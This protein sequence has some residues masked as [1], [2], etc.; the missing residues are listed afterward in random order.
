M[1]HLVKYKPE[2]SANY[3][4]KNPR[5]LM[6]KTV[7]HRAL[8]K[9]YEFDL[10]VEDI[11]IPTHCPILGI[12]LVNYFGTGIR[13]G[14]PDSPSCDRIDNTEGYV[15]GNIQIISHL[16]NQMKSSATPEELLKFAQWIKETY[17]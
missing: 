1:K 7:K 16:A 11:V 3:A 10:T 9:G 15:K 5:K 12:K 13:G 4:R 2:Y 6:L 14:R 17:K 8:Q